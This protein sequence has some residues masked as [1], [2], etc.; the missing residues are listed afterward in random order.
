MAKN[1]PQGKPKPQ[2]SQKVPERSTSRRSV[3]SK[4]RTP[5]KN[6]PSCT[7]KENHEAVP[8][9]VLRNALSGSLAQRRREPSGKVVYRA[10]SSPQAKPLVILDPAIDNYPNDLIPTHYHNTPI[11]RV[12]ASLHLCARINLRAPPLSSREQLHE[13]VATRTLRNP[14]SESLAQRR[15]VSISE[16]VHET[17]EII[18]KQFSPKVDEKP[19]LEVR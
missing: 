18:L 14:I 19:E 11:L 17:M 15:R 12:S 5:P 2:R 8:Q 3:R 9:S 10:R 16:I 6:S 13:T 7:R 1:P 4:H